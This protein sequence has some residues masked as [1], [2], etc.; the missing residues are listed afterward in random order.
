MNIIVIKQKKWLFGTVGLAVFSLI[1]V[2]IGL[3]L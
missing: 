1:L 3:L 2:G